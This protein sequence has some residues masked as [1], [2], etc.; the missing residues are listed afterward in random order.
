MCTKLLFTLYSCGSTVRK[1]WS[2]TL[3]Y[4]VATVSVSGRGFDFAASLKTL[5][6]QV[7]TKDA[8][9]APCFLWIPAYGQSTKALEFGLGFF[10]VAAPL[11]LNLLHCDLLLVT[12]IILNILVQ[13]V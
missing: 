9:W 7:S 4:A 2:S 12:R 3:K 5:F 6:S 8:P 11:P 1:W 13:D 10:S